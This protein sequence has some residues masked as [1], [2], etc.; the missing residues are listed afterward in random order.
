MAH[1]TPSQ[2]P[3]PPAAGAATARRITFLALVILGAGVPLLPTTAL[4]VAATLSAALVLA[5]GWYA[6]FRAGDP[7]GRTPLDVPIA[8]FFLA[9]VLAVLVSPN[10]SLSILFSSLR[11]DGML[12]Y[13]A[14]AGAALTAARLSRAEAR[15]LLAA[16]VSSGTLIGGIAVAQYYGV[17][18]TR[19]TA[20]MGA[21][22]TAQSA[23]TLGNRIFLGGYLCL[24]LPVC[25]ALAAD[26][27]E[28]HRQAYAAASGVAYAALVASQTRAAWVGAALGSVLLGWLLAGSPGALKRLLFLGGGFACITAVMALTQPH[29]LLAQ[30]AL[31]TLNLGDP[32]LE[33]R[34]A[35]WKQTLSL[36]RYR[37]MFGWGF[38][39]RLE[40]FP[41]MGSPGSQ[42]I[43]GNGPAVMDTTHNE[44][45][46]VA[47][48]AGV[49]GLGAYVWVWATLFIQLR[50]SL[51]A[52]QA[53]T[54]VSRA[55]IASLAAYLVWL[56]FAWSHLGPAN[57]FW[58]LAGI[59]VVGTGKPN[60]SSATIRYS[61]ESQRRSR[62]QADP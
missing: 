20:R 52:E 36:I 60:L 10:P 49:V 61:C 59:S 2:T 4:K 37:P 28:R 35:V 46:H 25:M 51:H 50:E 53:M 31:S 3:L 62:R 11:G 57:V 12:E 30:R 14:Y 39:T 24:L 29:A 38:S 22:P 18:L 48:I 6:R 47:Y 45:L 1:A 34:V 8:T 58:V 54:H 56:Q 44:I 7:L 32:S 15:A 13:V 23:G 5:G 27:M 40:Q 16:L 55:L 42:R 41:G 43:A 33:E 19:W 17:D 21:L 26:T 9:C